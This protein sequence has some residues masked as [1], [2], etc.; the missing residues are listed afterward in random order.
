[1]DEIGWETQHSV[2]TSASPAFTW[3]YITD[4]TNWYDPPARFKLDGLFAAGAYGTTEMPGHPPRALQIRDVQPMRSYIIEFPL[5]RA[6]LLFQWLFG[7][8]SDGRTLLTQ[9]IALNGEN[10]SAHVAEVTKRSEQILR[11]E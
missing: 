9:R 10:A 1:M 6:S 11:R 3:A 8:F 4:V 7:E 5:D 2:E